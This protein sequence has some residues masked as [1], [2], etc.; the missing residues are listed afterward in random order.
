MYYEAEAKYGSPAWDSEDI[1]A[2]TDEARQKIDRTLIGALPITG[3]VETGKGL[4]GACK[5]TVARPKGSESLP[6]PGTG[7]RFA[8]RPRKDV[9]IAM[10]RYGDEG[11]LTLLSAPAG[12]TTVMNVPRDNSS[13][14]WR[15]GFK[16]TGR[17]LLCQVKRGP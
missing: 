14:P 17:V 6:L 3:T 11:V 4:T 10:Q 8:V 13:R 5:V 15:V 12:R 2:A 7:R 1:E 9:F 16:G